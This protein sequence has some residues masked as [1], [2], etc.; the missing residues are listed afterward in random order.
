MFEQSITSEIRHSNRII[1][2]PL[3]AIGEYVIDAFPADLRRAAGGQ[4]EIRQELS[5]HIDALV[6][7]DSVA[8]THLSGEDEKRL[9]LLDLMVLHNGLIKVGAE[10]PRTLATAADELSTFLGQPTWLTY[11][12]IVRAN[13]PQDVRSF[14]GLE[15]EKLFY[16]NH[17]KF[18]R[19]M[20]PVLVGLRRIISDFEDVHRGITSFEGQ[21]Q[22]LA[23]H[24]D[25]CGES[26]REALKSLA[27]FMRMNVDDFNE[28]R[29]FFIEQPG[30]PG[31]S[32]L[33]S[34]HL[35]AFSLALAGNR[36]G[37]SLHR[38][39]QLLQFY[40][41]VEQEVL[42]WSL[43]AAHKDGCL[44]DYLQSPE[45]E[46]SVFQQAML[47]I[48]AEK[49]FLSAHRQMI[50]RAL[51]Q[52]YTENQGGTGG[53]PI[54]TFIDGTIQVYTEILAELGVRSRE[55]E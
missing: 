15:T 42:K 53:R 27:W 30:K 38:V 24:F 37:H 3:P 10:V 47:I 22:R 19:S 17:E 40:P 12:L 46:Q 7:R 14:T 25:I 21:Y 48:K 26:L 6:K 31:A 29:P 33:F 39:E 8:L 32:G 49:N 1:S 55:K 50:R 16:L 2:R 34:G 52:Q 18:E 11:E 44:V 9:A 4:E 41:Q 23:D 36:L 5:R 51:P 13:P 43:E 35:Q 54:K 20:E 45:V 28:F